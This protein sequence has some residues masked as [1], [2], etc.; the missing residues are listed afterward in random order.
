MTIAAVGTSVKHA[1][2]FTATPTSPAYVSV[3][4]AC[5]ISRYTLMLDSGTATVKFWKVALGTAI[6]TSSNSINTSGVSV[7]SGTAITSTTLSDFTTTSVAANDG[8]AMAITASSGPT[9]VN[10]V[11]LCTE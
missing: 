9:F 3:P 10:G 11:L 1:I 2:S 7:S 4:F 6:P 5:T 8:M